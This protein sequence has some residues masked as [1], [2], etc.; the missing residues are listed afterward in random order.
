MA[1]LQDVISDLNADGDDV[2]RMVAGLT[3]ER[4]AL[5][6]PAPGWTIAHLYVLFHSYPYSLGTPY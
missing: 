5:P 2:D 6:T 4:W 1:N 3:P